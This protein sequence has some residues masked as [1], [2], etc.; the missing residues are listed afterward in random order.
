MIGDKAYFSP[1]GSK[2]VYEF[3]N[4]QWHKLPPCPNKHFTI[5]SVDDM[6]TTVG[7]GQ[8]HNL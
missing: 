1:Y 3:S 5:V 7:G 8:T 4:N 6:L 2:T